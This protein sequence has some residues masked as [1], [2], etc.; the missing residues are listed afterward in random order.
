MV[1]QRCQQRNISSPLFFPSQHL[2]PS[3]QHISP[4]LEPFSPVIL[5]PDSLRLR[6]NPS[7]RRL[8]GAVLVVATTYILNV[9]TPVPLVESLV[10]VDGRRSN[11]QFANIYA[12][13]PNSV[14]M[15]NMPAYSSQ[16]LE[17]RSTD[18]NQSLTGGETAGLIVSILGLV[19]TALAVFKGWECWKSRK[20]SQLLSFYELFHSS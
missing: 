6:E 5:A 2:S 15:R 10:A 17:K 8:V 20:V 19:L 12:L 4:V 13:I 14:V 11:F 1:E 3:V 18:A 7:F 9:S 16:V